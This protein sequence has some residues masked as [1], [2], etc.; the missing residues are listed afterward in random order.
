MVTIN[1]QL[2]DMGLHQA[3]LDDEVK[4]LE[5]PLGFARR[6][7]VSKDQNTNHYRGQ[8]EQLH[9]TPSQSG[10]AQILISNLTNEL[11]LISTIMDEQVC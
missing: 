1:H 8:I 4:R 10:E 5:K 11:E 3:K 9:E 2:L 7:F 6:E